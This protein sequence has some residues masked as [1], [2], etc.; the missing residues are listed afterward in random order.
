MILKFPVNIRRAAMALAL[1]VPAGTIATPSPVAVA[2][3]T[4]APIVPS[5]VT[6]AANVQTVRDFYAAMLGARDY[7]LAERYLGP[8]YVQHAVGLADGKAGVERRI[9][10][11]SEQF[12]NITYEIKHTIADGN[13]VTIMTNIIRTPSTLGLALFHIYRLNDGKIVEHWETWQDVP[14]ESANSNG[15]F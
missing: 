13:I 11:I 10:E 3:L 8:E 12:P 14:T 2:R 7:K 5:F 6:E 9:A 1:A 15:I 4:T